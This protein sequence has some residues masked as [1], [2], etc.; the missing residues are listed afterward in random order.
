MSEANYSVDLDRY[1]STDLEACDEVEIVNVENR[2]GKMRKR[3]GRST[4][5]SSEDD[6][7]VLGSS[8]PAIHSKKGPTV[9]ST[10][11]ED[12]G[13]RA[14]PVG[15]AVKRLKGRRLQPCSSG[16][17]QAHNKEVLFVKESKAQTEKTG[18]SSGPPLPLKRAVQ[19][20]IWLWVPGNKGQQSQQNEMDATHSHDGV[21]RR[22]NEVKKRSASPDLPECT[23]LPPATTLQTSSVDEGISSLD[24]LHSF[25]EVGVSNREER[26]WSKGTPLYWTEC[27][28]CTVECMG[29]DCT[30]AYHSMKVEAEVEWDRVTRPMSENRFNV[31]RV[32]RIQ[33][34][35][36]W[37]R[38]RSE[39]EF[40]LDGAH[41]GY[42]LNQAWLYHVSTAGW[43]TVCEEGLDPR[44]AREG[45]F[46]RGTYFRWVWCVVKQ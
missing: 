32:F 36:L 40:M 37:K 24:V 9:I 38:Y 30:P 27:T 44:L 25:P 31:E 10:D 23:F 11:S 29:E 18:A 3:R 26:F 2:K 8:Q 43:R 7:I 20:G 6:V 41:E 1:S 19:D 4:S 22:H 14:V 15:L 45:C 42:Q 33:N 46:G 39:M 35:R 12:E 5:A 28:N 34:I 16:Q 13:S 21:A 17:A